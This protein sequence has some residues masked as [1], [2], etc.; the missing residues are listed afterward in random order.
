M[1]DQERV[2]R[3]PA[4]VAP[5]PELEGRL[6]AL[7]ETAP[8]W[9]GIFVTV[10]HKEIGLRYIVTA[11]AFLIAGGLEALAMR[12]QL[13]GPN[14]RLLTPEQYDELFTMHGV[15]MIFLYAMPILSGFSNYLWPLLLGSRDMAFPRV[16]ALSYWTFL[17]S[18]LF[19]YASFVLGVAPNAGWFNY[20]PYAEKAANPG[21]NIDFYALGMIFLGISTTVG[22]INFVVTIMRTRAPGMSINRLPIIVWGTLTASVANILVVPSVSLAFL[23]LWLDRNFG[24]HFFTEGNGGQPLLWQHLFWMFGHPW[25]YAV[26]LPA[27]GFVSDGLPIFCRRPLVGYTLVALSTVA[28]MALGF[29]VWVHHMFATGIS[30]M[31]LAFFSSVS[32]VITV[33][34]AIAV[35][36]WIATIWTGRPQ[37]TAAFHFYAGTIALFVIGGVS[38]VMTASA[39]VDWQ[40][41]DTYFIVAHLHYTLIGINVFPVI[42]AFYTWLPKMTGRMLDERLGKWNFWLMFIGFN[43]AFFPMHI[44]GLLG[45]PRRVYTYPADMA[46]SSLNLIT[47]IGSFL[48]AFG[49]LL[50]IIN[51]FV[52]LR[53]R[54]VAGANPWDAGTLEW[55]TPSPPPPYNFAVIPQV[56]S[57]HPLW[58]DRLGDPGAS[59]LD[60][61]LALDDGREIVATTVLD[62]EPDRVLR[63][64]GDSWLPFLL[65]V[66]TTFVF[67]GLLAHVWALAAGATLACA[68]VLIVWLQPN[69]APPLIITGEAEHV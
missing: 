52:S 51:V 10:D 61:G 26:V 11:F 59:I 40:L 43:L 22:A 69:P 23:M 57:R 12:L 14:L 19:I 31:A 17:F 49:I 48:F 54:A 30:S 60:R 32:F 58:E 39:P 36:C 3:L 25:V 56:G 27:M 1:V 24:S 9:R 50:F 20:A 34:S 7:W 42:G 45:M 6:H 46:W 29:G 2:I 63:M 13:A 66:A 44:S 21:V 16:N 55:L 47:T 5:S 18:G 65:G 68:V 38:G 35:F 33:P 8:G 53:R 62:G 41:T 64:P 4:L 28:T 67:I 37:A 15:S